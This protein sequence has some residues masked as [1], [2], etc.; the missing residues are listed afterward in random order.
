MI[1]FL[2]TCERGNRGERV[3]QRDF[4]LNHVYRNMKRLIEEF[5]LR[6]DAAEPVPADDALA[7]RV[8]DAAVE[9][10]AA[11]GVYFQDAGRVARF[12]RNE[13]LAAAADHPG[14]VRLGSGAEARTLRPRKPDGNTRPW[15]HVGSGIVASS[16]RLAEQ[17]VRGNA[18][19]ETADSMSVNALDKIDGR[20]I[21]PGEPSEIL[22]ALRSIEVARRACRLAGREGLAILNGIATASSALGTIA[23]AGCPTSLGPGDAV[24]VDTLPEFKVNAEELAKAAYCQASKTNLMTASAPMLGGFAGGPEGLAILNTAYALFGLLVYRCDIYLT[25]PIHIH[26]SC[27]TTRDMIWATALSGQAI[28]RNTN[29]PTLALAYACGG[30]WTESFYYESGAFIAAA[31]ASGVSIQTPHPA[32]AVAT[33]HVTPLEMWTTTRMAL[34]C[35]GMTRSE[36]NEVVLR[37]LPLYEDGLPTASVGK[38]YAECCDEETGAPRDAYLEFVRGIERTLVGAGVPFQ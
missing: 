36:A 19:I 15:C 21:R 2:E 29:L 6:Y 10:I 37:V 27:G 26:L 23:A 32:K 1:E 31:V 8:F 4:D 24:I 28:A 7:D 34:G 30:P 35:T 13:V 17:I 18:S 9:F 12:T 11:S 38:S 33:D 20:A 14:E 16:E 5:E 3:N 22:G 25:L